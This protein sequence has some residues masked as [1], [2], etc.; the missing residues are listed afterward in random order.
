[1]NLIGTNERF[2]KAYSL[3]L[4]NISQKKNIEFYYDEELI[5]FMIKALRQGNRVNCLEYDKLDKLFNYVSDIFSLH[6][7]IYALLSHNGREQSIS[8]KEDKNEPQEL[9]DYVFEDSNL[10]KFEVNHKKETCKCFFHKVLLYGDRWKKGIYD[11]EAV[12]LVL[13]L[14][15]VKHIELKGSFD[16]EFLTLNKVYSSKNIRLS[17]NNYCVAILCVANY[18]HFIMEITFS[19]VSAE[20]FSYDS[21]EFNQLN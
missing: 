10:L 1:M 2:A 4:Q 14:T 17:D 19:S 5:G 20:E 7:K 3:K 21:C 9:S 16:F 15:G 6:D 8:H 12:D 18:E 11:V 13:T